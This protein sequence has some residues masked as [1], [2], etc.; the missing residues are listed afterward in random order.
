MLKRIAGISAAPS[1]NVFKNI[2][3]D[4]DP[5]FSDNA[6]YIKPEENLKVF[7]NKYKQS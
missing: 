1:R 3:P 7:Q 4:R 5:E 6:K 2:S